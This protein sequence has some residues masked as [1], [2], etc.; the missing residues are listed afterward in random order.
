MNALTHVK[1]KTTR[2]LRHRV[3]WFVGAR[4]GLYFPIFR[5][6]SGYDDLLVD[7]TT[8]ICIEGYPRSANSFAVGAFEHAQSAPVRVAHHT[9]VPANPM[10]ACER[11]VPTLVLI[12]DPHDAVVSHVALGKQ[13]QVTEQGV[14]APVQWLS[15]ETLLNAWCT[16]YRSVRPYRNRMVVASLGAVVEDMGAVIG[17]V[18]AH[19]GTDF[20]RFEHTPDA[21]AEVHSGRGYHAGPSEHRDQLK[22]DTRTDFEK[23]L[24]FDSELEATLSEAETCYEAFVNDSATVTVS[25]L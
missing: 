1:E 14:E 5:R 7:D 25:S 10:R 6:R 22:A 13:T 23:R 15:F 24:R 19:F 12:R 9:H 8:D 4:P 21:V 20:D 16:F 17:Q 2:T 11:G 18:N 3:K